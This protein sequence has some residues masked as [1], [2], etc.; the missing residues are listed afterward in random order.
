MRS[1]LPDLLQLVKTEQI[2]IPDD[3][4]ITHDNV[5]LDSGCE[6]FLNFA[7]RE[8]GYLKVLLNPSDA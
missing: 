8:S 4:L 3:V 7:N 1:L 6:A 5:P 2:K